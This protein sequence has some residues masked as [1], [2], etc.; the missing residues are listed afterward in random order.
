MDANKDNVVTKDEFHAAVEKIV[1]GGPA[2]L[3]E[4]F[5]GSIKAVFP[6]IDT[7]KNG[8]IS[9]DEAQASVKRIT[10]SQ[11]D[12]AIHKAYDWLKGK[13]KTGKVDP[14]TVFEGIW[15][16]ASSPNPTPEAE[17]IFPYYRRH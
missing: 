2:K 15:E 5:A 9:F 14:D 1:A 3:P 10:P 6:I 12:E 7:N 8:D 11:N 17:I 13:S 4:W 16:W